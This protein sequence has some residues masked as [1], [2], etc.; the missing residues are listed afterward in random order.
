M[1]DRKWRSAQ[2]VRR[3]WPGLHI[4]L[5]SLLSPGLKRLLCHGGALIRLSQQMGSFALGTEKLKSPCT[6]YAYPSSI[7]ILR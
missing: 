1:G 3:G 4:I 7:K 2:E 5:F 6:S